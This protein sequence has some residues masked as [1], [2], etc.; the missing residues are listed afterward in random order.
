MIQSVMLSLEACTGG[1]MSPVLRH[2]GL[3]PRTGKDK[4]CAENS[5]ERERERK[6]EGERDRLHSLRAIGFL[7]E[8]GGQVC[9]V[10]S[11][12]RR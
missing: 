7:N 6:R 9:N 2:H 4:K 10:E 12:I 8:K 5:E 3:I 1:D 11:A